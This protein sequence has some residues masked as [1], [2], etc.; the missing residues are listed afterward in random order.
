MSK[1]FYVCM[2]PT[3]VA[4]FFFFFLGFS[5]FVFLFSLSGCFSCILPM[6]LACPSMLLN[7][8]GF[9]LIGKIGLFI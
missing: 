8:I 9:F 6:Y 2:A 4:T 1:S 5:C 7:E 3:A